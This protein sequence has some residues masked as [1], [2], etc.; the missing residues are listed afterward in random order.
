MK[1]YPERLADFL[2]PETH[3]CEKCGATDPVEIEAPADTDM[4]GCPIS[5]CCLHWIIDV[6]GNPKG[7]EGT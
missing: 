4:V 3:Y 1:T 5:E 6:D 7:L 2:E